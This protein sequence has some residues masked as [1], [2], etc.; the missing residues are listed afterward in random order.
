MLS[1]RERLVKNSYHTITI[2]GMTSEGLGTGILEGIPV[3]VKKALPGELVN[4]K[5][6]KITPTLAIGKLI[7]IINPAADRVD[8]FCKIFS[9]CGGCSLQHLGYESQVRFK[10][11]RVRELAGTAA[12]F[13]NIIIHKTLGM[14]TPLHYRNKALYPVGQKGGAPVLGFYANRSH[15]IVEHS[16]CDIQPEIV[17]TIRAAVRDFL[18][19]YKISLYDETRHVGLARHLMV[20][21]SVKTGEIMVVLVI[22][23]SHLPRQ[24]LFVKQLTTKVPGITSIILNSNLEDTNAILGETNRVLYGKSVITDILGDLRFEVSPGSFYQVNPAQTEVLYRKV[25]EYAELSETETVVDLYCGIGTISLFLASHANK[26]YGVEIVEE[27]VQDAIRNAHVN[28]ITNADFFQ[29]AA[30]DGLPRMIQQGVTPDVVLVDPPRK[31]CGERVLETLC[32]IRPKRLIYVSCDP[33]TLIR[34]LDFLAAHGFH[35]AEIQPVDMFPHTTHVECIA[36]LKPV[37]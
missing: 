10:T 24:A 11:E 36:R 6:I 4:I 2:T 5:I 19:T 7:E 25:L 30:E 29:G 22:N 21:A 32:H 28:G 27:A 17:N 14:D 20:R 15:D 23:G 3:I 8:P 35:V 31:G 33:K 18:L 9:R 13:T 37:S 26:M 34:D 1:M 12:A 16:T